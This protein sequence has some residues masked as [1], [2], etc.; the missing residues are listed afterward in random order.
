M[1][2]LILGFLLIFGISSALFA[3]VDFIALA[4][5]GKFNEQS[6][7]VKLLNDDEMSKVVGGAT[8]FD[9]NGCGNLMYHYGIANN[10]GTRV[11]YTAYY[12][13]HESYKNELL[14]LNVDDG[15]G[16]YISVVSATLNHLT[17]Q[18]NVSIIGMNQ[19]N[20]VYTR[21]ADRYYANKLLENR[22][23]INEVNNVIR[24]HS[25]YFWRY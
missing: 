4:T 2:K 20:S 14:P 17:N 25:R 9:D 10:G 24:N 11:S 19:Y 23:V 18:V 12:R 5:N 13:L 22:Q 1:K 15:S 6:A 21:S 3:E 8:L 7:G 16:R